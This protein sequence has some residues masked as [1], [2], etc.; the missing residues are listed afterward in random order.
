MT[1]SGLEP[2]QDAGTVVLQP[3]LPPDR[4]S[5]TPHYRRSPTLKGIAG[6][7]ARA[8][9]HQSIAA[10]GSCL[11]SQSFVRYRS[12]ARSSTWASIGVR[13]GLSFVSRDS[14]TSSMTFTAKHVANR[15]ENLLA[16]NTVSI[17][18][19]RS[20]EIRFDP[21]TRIIDCHRLRGCWAYLLTHRLPPGIGERFSVADAP[22]SQRIEGAGHFAPHVLIVKFF[23]DRPFRREAGA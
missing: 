15:S 2:L 10:T 21:L 22:T 1:H 11:I 19:V 8:A 20:N 3:V 7:E 5:I 13:F 18:A 14:T 9:R 12:F 4:S 6:A 16:D 23:E 17:E